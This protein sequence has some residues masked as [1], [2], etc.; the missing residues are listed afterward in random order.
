MSGMRCGFV[1]VVGR[2]NTGKSTLVNALVGEKVSIVTPRPQTTRHRVLGIRTRADS[3][4]VFV[5]TPGLQAR[6]G[7]LI[8]RTMNRAAAGSVTD[9]DVV[10]FVVEAT[11]WRPGDEHVLGRLASCRSPVILVV[12]KADLVRPKS[13]LLPLLVRLEGRRE[14]AAIVPVSALGADNLESLVAT[15]LRHLPE[16][17]PFF[18]GDVTTDRGREFRIGELLRE[19]LMATLKSEVP[20]GVAVEITAVD[21]AGATV[22]VDALIWVAKDSQ[23]PIVIGRGG[24]TLKAIGS[25]ARLEIEKLLGRRVF[26]QTHVKVRR[27]WADDARALRQ[28]GHDIEG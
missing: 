21:D 20:Y 2:P 1:A 4:V 10:L 24:A 16:G 19:Q 25:G 12:N 17:E 23:R 7:K 28:L 27:N 14:F 3:Q 15:V 5:D 13:K 9:A 18:P 8:N 22:N 6:A 11:G 26:L